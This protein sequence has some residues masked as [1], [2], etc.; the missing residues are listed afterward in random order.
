MAQSLWF[1][2]YSNIYW[3]NYKE[4]IVYKK[5]KLDNSSGK[6]LVIMVKTPKTILC[7]SHESV[8]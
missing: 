2:A 7:F 5:K 4:A 6:F 3:I 8:P 1:V